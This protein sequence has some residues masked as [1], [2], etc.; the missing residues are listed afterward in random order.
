MD[1]H[2]SCER[3]G[4]RYFVADV[5]TIESEGKVVILALCTACG[6]HLRIDETV[7]GKGS[8]FRTRTNEKEKNEYVQL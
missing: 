7:T 2:P 5:A 1:V 3:L 6:Q 8:P 4:H